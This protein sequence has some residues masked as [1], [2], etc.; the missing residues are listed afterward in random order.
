M[1][2]TTKQTTHR[3]GTLRRNLAPAHESNPRT[4]SSQSPELAALYQTALDLANYHDLPELLQAIVERAVALIGAHSGAIGIYDPAYDEIELTA[5][6]GVHLPYGLRRH[7]GDGMVG[8][9]IETR[10]PLIVNDYP[11]S[12]YGA[13]WRTGASPLH[14][15]LNVP[16]IYRDELLGVLSLYEIADSPRTFD[17]ADA[18]LIT[19]LAT[20]AASAVKNARMRARAERSAE[21]DRIVAGIATRFIKLDPD[22]VDA[23]ID[24]TLRLIGEFAAVDRAYLFRISGDGTRMDNTHEWCAQGIEP[25]IANLQDLDTAL[26]PWTMARFARGEVTHARSL[27]DLPPEAAVEKEVLAAQDIQSVVLIPILFD[28]KAIGFIGFDAVRHA[29]NWDDH[30]IDL[31]RLIAEVFSLAL[32]RA[33]AERDLRLLNHELE[34]RVVERTAALRASEEQMRLLVDNSLQGIVLFQNNRLVFT[35]RA[36]ADMVGFSIDELLA[37]TE[38]QLMQ[39]VHPDDRHLI[40]EGGSVFAPGKPQRV[41]LQFRIFHRSGAVRWMMCMAVLLLHEGAPAI[42]AVMV[43]VTDYK[44]AEQSLME[45]KRFIE[46]ITE[47]GL[48]LIYVYD[49]AT[50]GDVYIN[51]TA[52]A[53]LGYSA[54]DAASMGSAFLRA[55]IH[56]NDLPGVLAKHDRYAALRDGEYIE[57]EVRVRNK[58]GQWRWLL[59]R[60]L[61][62]QRDAAGQPLQVLGVSMDI[63]EIK[64]SKQ[65][66]QE[67]EER[68]RLLAEN[69]SDLICLQEADGRLLYASPAAA[70]LLGYTP[71]ELLAQSLIGL[72]PPDEQAKLSALCREHI[73]QPV[74]A[75][76]AIEHQARHRAGEYIWLDTSF[77]V[78]VNHRS[79]SRQLISVS[80]NVTQR[81]LAETA[82]LNALAKERELGELKSRFVAMTSHEFRTPLAAILAN[83]ETL[84]HYRSRL[85]A[86]QIDLRLSR[87]CGQVDHLSQMIDEILSLTKVQSGRMTA[88]LEPLDLG[89]FCARIVEEYRG[90][91][92]VKH[93]IRFTRADAPLTVEADAKLLRTVIT[94]LITNAI[95]YSPDG[96]DICVAVVQRS[97]EAILR[98]TDGGIG[99]P[100]KDQERLFQA[101]H[102]AS[103]VGSLAGTGLGLSI[104]KEFLELMGGAISFESQVGAGTT[105]EIALPVHA[106][107]SS[108]E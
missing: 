8:Q 56:P 101:F 42:Q 17:D 88:A 2:R 80:R 93:T 52:A 51:T 70:A 55:V 84:L 107:R 72:S 39:R 27:A 61:I 60:D 104:A 46:Q 49:L 103:N 67:S 92:D 59:T 89:Q 10:V 43:D 12:P 41:T 15:A 47:T 32:G 38:A 18:N 86:Q 37:A 23:E 74:G 22:S 57:Q 62:F 94:N 100:E 87:I 105:F 13:A 24:E 19:A 64:R 108:R 29:R 3:R 14:A 44:L 21:M 102:R 35:N 45:S 77:S 97:A 98:V 33:E 96:T 66:L 36:M 73:A 54:E 82:L 5:Q 68:F 1:Q 40:W 7:R 90:R 75:S 91:A 4:P 78:T 30:D 34:A 25:Q 81:K 85:D 83:A 76:V 95:K 71:G 20:V 26:M 16:M 53:F 63:S 50:R 69:S 11:A 58:E 6:A 48:N 79:G 9:V 65:A 31:L 99:I 28:K 106:E